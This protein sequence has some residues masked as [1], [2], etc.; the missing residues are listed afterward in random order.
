MKKIFVF[1]AV[2]SAFS[3]A[4]CKKDHSCS[5][6]YT[7]STTEVTDWEVSPTETET[8]S[9]SGPYIVIINDAKKKDAKKYCIDETSTDTEVSEGNGYY[10]NN[11]FGTQE[12][13]VRTTTTKSEAACSLK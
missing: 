12:S 1:A 10:Q 7:S 4:S 13:Y 8:S 11:F 9:T 5:C 3:F 2:I 6:T